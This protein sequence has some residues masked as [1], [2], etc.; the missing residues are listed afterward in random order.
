MLINWHFS[1][2]PEVK[3]TMNNDVHGSVPMVY[4]YFRHLKKKD[5]TRLLNLFADDATIHEP[6]SNI[7]AGLKGKS[8]I[9]PFLEVAMMAYD[10]MRDEIE[11]E[12]SIANKNDAKNQVTALVT[13]EKGG[14]VRARYNFEL[15]TGSDSDLN[16]QGKKIQTLRIE[17]IE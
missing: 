9:K 17:F 11:F 1:Y 2:Q 6:F 3:E 4:E 15:S 12:K 14:R 16:C 8:A 5:A 7:D 13:F 10:G